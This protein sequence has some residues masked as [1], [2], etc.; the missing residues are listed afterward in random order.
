MYNNNNKKGTSSHLSRPIAFSQFLSFVSRRIVSRFASPL[1]ISR[2][3]TPLSKS[4]AV[5]SQVNSHSNESCLSLPKLSTDVRHC[6]GLYL[7][8]VHHLENAHSGDRVQQQDSKG[9]HSHIQATPRVLNISKLTECAAL[10]PS[11]ERPFRPEPIYGKDV[12]GEQ[13]GQRRE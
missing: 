2:S 3:T 1:I 13:V 5:L 8:W 12:H 6:G 4:H 10:K 7:H 11:L 9:C